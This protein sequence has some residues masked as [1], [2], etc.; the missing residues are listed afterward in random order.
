MSPF[1]FLLLASYVVPI[2]AA[3]IF[4]FRGQ[5]IWAGAATAAGAF[6]HQLMGLTS[7]CTQGAD[8]TFGAGAILS[9]PL[10][11]IAIGVSLRAL[12]QKKVHPIGSWMTLGLPLILLALTHGAWFNTL[13][14]R[15]PCG[16]DFGFGGGSSP[17]MIAVILFGYLALPLLLAAIAGGLLITSRRLYEAPIK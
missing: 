2:V 16:E 1:I 10:L 5:W 9:A 12:Y 6:P 13:R 8:G 15:T 11:L 17:I 14:Y 4:A 3:I 7:T